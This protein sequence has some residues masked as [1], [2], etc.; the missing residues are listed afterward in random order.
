MSRFSDCKARLLDLA[1]RPHEYWL[2]SAIVL[3]LVIAYSVWHGGQRASKSFYEMAAQIIPVLILAL[4]VERNVQH[5]WRQWHPTCRLQVLVALAVAESAALIGATL[6]QEE[7][8]VDGTT[9]ALLDTRR[10][11]PHIEQGIEKGLKTDVTVAIPDERSTEYL[12][13]SWQWFTDLL[14]WL[15][16]V[17]LLVGFLAVI[18]TTMLRSAVDDWRHKRHA[19]RPVSPSEAAAKRGQDTEAG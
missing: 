18:W 17:G 19:W 6:G 4:A 14:T 10:A 12:V 5:G 11:V 3:T 9:A 13:G 16:V 2:T 7:L 1:K 8:S 15:T